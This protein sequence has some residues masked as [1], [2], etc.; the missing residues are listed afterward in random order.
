[1][2][3]REFPGENKRITPLITSDW[4]KSES[5]WEHPRNIL[6]LHGPLAK[7]RDVISRTHLVHLRGSSS[8]KRGWVLFFFTLRPHK[9]H[10]FHRL[11]ACVGMS[12]FFFLWEDEI[13][14]MD[15]NWRKAC[16]R[17][18]KMRP[19]TKPKREENPQIGCETYRSPFYVT[20]AINE[21][22]I[23]FIS[24]RLE[25]ETKATNCGS[26]LIWSDLRFS[27]LCRWSCD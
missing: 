2:K 21:S 18:Q 4:R 9:E 13:M 7:R 26:D 19:E 20:A 22:T 12:H 24:T 8:F 14:Q 11:L 17:R 6:R 16:P 25:S 10:L 5:E 27:T 3:S 15:R 1:M 23:T